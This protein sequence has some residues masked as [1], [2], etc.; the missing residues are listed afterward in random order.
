MRYVWVLSTLLLVTVSLGRA[1][2][3]EELAAEATQE[4]AM[5]SVPMQMA[6]V[7]GVSYEEA[8]TILENRRGELQQIP[9][10]QDAGLGED[11]IYVY[12]EEWAS[13]PLTLDGLPVKRLPLIGV[14]VAGRSYIE[15]EA[16]FSR[17]RTELERL[18]RVQGVALSEKGIAVYSDRPEQL[19]V[20]IE[21]IPVVAVEPM[22]VPVNGI[23]VIDVEDIFKR[24]EQTYLTTVPGCKSVGLGPDGIHV[25]TTQP[26]LVPKEVEGVP[27]KVVAVTPP[28]EAAE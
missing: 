21:G 7:A 10:V 15:A 11:G 24:Y 19:P 9:G 4:E 2:E 18:P 6:P 28:E 27:V 22:G 1:H 13:L 25:Y 20:S 8:V 5:V 16:I 12:A 26:E 14:P 17:H 23:S 3:G